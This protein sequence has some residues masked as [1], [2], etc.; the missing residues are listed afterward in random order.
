MAFGKALTAAGSGVILIS[1]FLP[2]VGFSGLDMTR[3]ALTSGNDATGKAVALTICLAG[4]VAGVVGLIGVFANKPSLSR[5]FLLLGTLVWVLLFGYMA[6][7]DGGQQ[8]LLSL[9]KAFKA[10]LSQTFGLFLTLVGLPA[11]A[12]LSL[13]WRPARFRE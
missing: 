7:Q 2:W 12:I 5:T 4:A 6:T 9:G 3:A 1:Y 11:T 10:N 8:E 13:F